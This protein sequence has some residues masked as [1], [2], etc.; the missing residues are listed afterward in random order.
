MQPL[1]YC[2][3]TDIDFYNLDPNKQAQIYKIYF[4]LVKI[5][6]LFIIAILLTLI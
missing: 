6:N 4:I 3:D 2:N 5:V 1:F